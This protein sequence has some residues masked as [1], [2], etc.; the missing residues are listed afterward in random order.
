ML[1]LEN[2]HQFVGPDS[3]SQFRMSPDRFDSEASDI[4]RISGYCSSPLS[5]SR[6]SPAKPVIRELLASFRTPR[7]SC[8]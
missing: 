2:Q 8:A 1:E 7:R 3:N 4:V 5:V 6:V